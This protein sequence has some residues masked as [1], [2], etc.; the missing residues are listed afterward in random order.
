MIF[1]DT[2]IYKNNQTSIPSKI[3][4]E[5]NVGPDD[6]IE[7]TLDDDGKITLN[8]RKKITFKEMR[9]AINLGHKTNAVELEKE[10]YNE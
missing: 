4:K 10:L 1:A 7:W 2:K 5:C 6:I 8:F 3:R 9:G